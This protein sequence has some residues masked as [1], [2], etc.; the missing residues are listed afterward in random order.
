[1]CEIGVADGVIVISGD[2]D[3]GAVVVRFGV[4][5]DDVVG[6][7]ELTCVVD[8]YGPVGG[9]VVGV[10]VST[11]V[12]DF[13]VGCV[14]NV[15][16]VGA[17]VARFGVVTDDV[18]GPLE[19][20]CVVDGYG[21]VGGTVVVCNEDGGNGNVNVVSAVVAAVISV[22]NTLGVVV[23]IPTSVVVSLV[24]VC[25]GVGTAGDVLLVCGMVGHAGD[26]R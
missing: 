18:V 5:T 1:M 15:V 26:D 2:E 14:K 7:L 13:G 25:N 20:T 6:P 10:P 19:I 12:A 16:P 9:T 22:G 21:P 11:V 3:V 17:V 4:V 8:G 23:V 24:L